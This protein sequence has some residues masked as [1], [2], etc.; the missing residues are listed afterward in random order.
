[1]G[2]KFQWLSMKKIL[3]ISALIATA[4]ML[5]TPLGVGAV[6]SDF[7]YHPSLSYVQ[8]G[9]ATTLPQGLPLCKSASLG[10]IVCY[11]PSFI[12]KAYEFPST[13]TLDGSGQTIVIVDAFGSPTIASDLALFDARFGISAPPSFTIFCGNSPTPL[14]PSTCPVVNI[15]ANPKHD[16][17]GWTI[18][19]SLDVEY[20]H[21]MA[22][23]AN[24]VLDVASTS[25]GNAINDAETAAIAAYPGAIFSQSFGIPEIFLTGNGNPGQVSQAQANY[26]NGV[27]KGDTF[28]ASAGDTGADFGFGVPMSNFPGSD[29]HSGI[30]LQCNWDSH[31]LPDLHTFFMHF[32][33]IRLSRSMCPRPNYTTELCT[34]WVW[35]RTGLE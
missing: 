4:L 7:H 8:L 3:T 25:S 30:A 29:L 13:S 2:S 16:E 26:A 1:M 5:A 22:P 19:T 11:S 14:D 12:K 15:N 28:F 6:V 33:T 32:R 18:E 23:G 31:A 17:F 34:R 35:W 9:P 24:I 27:A 21:A 10:N 20:A